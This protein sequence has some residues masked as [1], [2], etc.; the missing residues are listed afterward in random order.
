M[1][2]A[3]KQGVAESTVEVRWVPARSWL[4][5]LALTPCYANEVLSFSEL[6]DKDF[7]LFI[8][9]YGHDRCA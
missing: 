8:L 5:S 3:G 4:Q 6:A 9:G 7:K 2:L 1:K